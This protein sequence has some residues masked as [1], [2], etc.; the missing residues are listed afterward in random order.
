MSKLARKLRKRKRRERDNKRQ[1]L[2]DKER[3]LEVQRRQR[4]KSLYPEFHFD[5][6][7][8]H[9]DF[10]RAVK[11][12]VA[13][14]NFED[15]SVFPRW[16]ADLYRLL[17]VEGT[18]ALREAFLTLKL[19]CDANERADGQLAEL[20]FVFNLG[21][22]VLDRI[23]KDIRDRHLPMSDV[24]VTPK[25][26]YIQVICRS[27]C[28]EKG[29]GGTIYYSRRKPTLDIDG[30]PKIVAFSKHAIDQTSKRINP[31]STTSYGALGDIFSFFDQCTYFE[32]TTLHRDQLGFSFFDRCTAGSVTHWYVK[33]VLGT[34]NLDLRQGR[35][36]YRV[37]YCPAVVEGDFVKAMTLLLPGYA[38][39]PECSAIWDHANTR[40]E[41]EE[42]LARSKDW[43]PRMLYETHD[44]SLL[45]WF[46]DHGVPQVVHLNG[47]VYDDM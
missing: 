25:R 39:T 28:R 41:R 8:A 34:E 1:K 26:N 43:T 15:R 46:H 35:P 42:L 20:H 33:E 16:E 12:S 4:Y 6:V 27:L 40:T 31:N 21:Q 44:F 3:R 32:R 22:I 9:P 10:T 45:K 14:I 23:P 47:K 2:R 11:Q 38:N 13:T 24:M 29:D 30:D 5:T 18:P 7:S 17:K 37:G 36:Y 19:A